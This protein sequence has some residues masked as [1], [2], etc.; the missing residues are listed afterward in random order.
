MATYTA[1]VLVGHSH[2]NHG[3][4]TPTHELFLSENDKPAWILVPHLPTSGFRNKIWIPTVENML[5]DGLLMINALVLRDKDIRS[6]LMQFCKRLSSIKLY[7][8]PVN[9]LRK[10]HARS[11][12]VYEGMNVKMCLSIYEE[13]TL[14][15]QLKVLKEYPFEMEVCQTTFSRSQ[16]M[17]AGKT[18]S[19]GTL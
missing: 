6:S 13:S 19:K 17:W 15:K 18:V 14:K 16:S 10:I 3:G 2:P 7:S 11:R 8:I 4:I 1:S 5:E 9:D 12:D